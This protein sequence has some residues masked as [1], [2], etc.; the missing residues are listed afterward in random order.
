MSK[1]IICGIIPDNIEFGYWERYYKVCQRFEY[2]I[3]QIVK[4]G[5][6]H[7]SFDALDGSQIYGNRVNNW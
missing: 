4:N 3:K 6:T 1:G 5:N 2:Q 7:L